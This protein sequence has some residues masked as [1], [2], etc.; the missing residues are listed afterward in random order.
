MWTRKIKRET[1]T[2]E[3]RI[4]RIREKLAGFKDLSPS[5]TFVSR[6]PK[7][8]VLVELD[9]KVNHDGTIEWSKDKVKDMLVRE[10]ESLATAP[11]SDIRAMLRFLPHFEAWK[12]K[13]GEKS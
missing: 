2:D 8:D 9:R 6:E 5:A 13:Q 12:E 11:D 7:V 4:R 3:E 1:V 10:Y